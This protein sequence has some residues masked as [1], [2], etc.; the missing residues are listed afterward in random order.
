MILKYFKFLILPAVIAFASCSSQNEVKKP[1]KLIEVDKM[2][3]VYIDLL[4]VDAFAIAHPN[5]RDSAHFDI[6][7]M[8]N[9]VFSRHHVS[10]EQVK[11]SLD[12]Y[13]HNPTNQENIFQSVTDTLSSM[14]AYTK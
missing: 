13:L 12:Y 5:D 4:T 7:Q 8:Y 9:D 3:D 6:P 14:E 10:K 1:D 11:A 2:K